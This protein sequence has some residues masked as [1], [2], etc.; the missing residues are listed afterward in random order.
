[1][2]ASLLVVVVAPVQCWVLKGDAPAFVK[3]EGPL[4]FMGPTWR[5]ELN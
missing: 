5:I 3:F 4:Y 2:L 1:M